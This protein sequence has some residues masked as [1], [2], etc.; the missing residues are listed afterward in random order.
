MAAK[1]RMLA[2]QGAI[3]DRSMSRFRRR[4]GK[5]KELE[6]SEEYDVLLSALASKESWKRYFHSGLRGVKLSEDGYRLAITLAPPS[7]SEIQTVAKPV[8]AISYG[9]TQDYGW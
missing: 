1:S 9:A 7:L 6:G 2:P 3:D 5:D 4:T 8:L